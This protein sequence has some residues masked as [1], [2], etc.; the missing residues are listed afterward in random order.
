MRISKEEILH[1]A[2]LARL[3]MQQ[4]DMA[5]MADQLGTILAYVDTLQAVDT[6][7]IAPMSHAVHLVNALR[8]DVIGEHV[9][10]EMALANAPEP[11]DG[12]FM[13]PKIV[14]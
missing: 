14:G 12:H 7:G 6:Q 2:G 1:V 11:E 3:H 4:E 10:V 5:R 9:G 13:V 8:E